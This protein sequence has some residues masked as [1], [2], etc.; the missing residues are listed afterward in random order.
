MT[1][2]VLPY[3]LRSLAQVQGEVE[4]EAKTVGE[5]LDALE[6]EHPVL[7]GT[8]RDPATGKRRNF[9]RFFACK[10]DLSHTSYDEPL[11]SAVLE[12]SEPFLVVGAMAGG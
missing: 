4:V 12:G 11:P 2:V 6:A 5:V 7:V 3:H 8:M 1:R 10:E 9:V